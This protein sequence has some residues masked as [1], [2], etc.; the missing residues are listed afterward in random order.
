VL[1]AGPTAA[2]VESP[3][4]PGCSFAEGEFP[5]VTP[6]RATDPANTL[7]VRSRTAQ[8]LCLADPSGRFVPHA[9]EAGAEQRFEGRPPWK[10]QAERLNEIDIV[11][12][13][14]PLRRP[15]YIKDRMELLERPLAA[16]AG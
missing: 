1:A 4:A 7:L 2:R 12:Q 8:T 10:L 14:L 9:L 6:L 15:A 3:G 13:G 5:Q 16:P 11:Y